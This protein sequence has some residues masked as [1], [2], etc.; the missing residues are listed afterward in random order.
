[1]K[2]ILLILIFFIIPFVSSYTI[3][4]N[5]TFTINLTE[6]LNICNCTEI[7]INITHPLCNN[8]AN[9]EEC[10]V[11]PENQ[12]ALDSLNSQI[13]N[14]SSQITSL[15]LQLAI[16][17]NN[18]SF[19]QTQI[20]N[21]TSEVAK[22]EKL[23]NDL[24]TNLTRECPACPSIPSCPACPACTI[25]SLPSC[26]SYNLTCPQ[27]QIIMPNP[28]EEENKPSKPWLPWILS[29]LFFIMLVITFINSAKKNE[30]KRE[31]ESASDEFIEEFE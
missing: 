14:L 17:Q 20:N 3:D 26:P 2:K 21:L 10:P 15:N 7:T 13:T 16:S 8:S 23:I 11:C 6:I 30:K 4:A 31:P 24:L 12:S 25:P 29:G 9:C 1:M 27:S 18:I 5:E 22:K 19:Y 28:N